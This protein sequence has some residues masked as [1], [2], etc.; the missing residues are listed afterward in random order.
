MPQTMRRRQSN[1]NQMLDSDSY[2]ADSN[3]SAETFVTSIGEYETPRPVTTTATNS[4]GY[5]PTPKYSDAS[6][7]G[8]RSFFY[9]NDGFQHEL[10]ANGGEMLEG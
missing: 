1:P 2:R 5:L 3:A 8:Q 4:I 9:N 7:F 10:D 6:N